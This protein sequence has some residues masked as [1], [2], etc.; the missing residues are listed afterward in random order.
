MLD[1]KTFDEGWPEF[2][3]LAEQ[4]PGLIQESVTRFDQ[5]LFGSGDIQRFY[6]FSFKDRQ[7]LEEALTTEIGE[8]AGK[9]LHIISGG[10]LTILA[11][12]FQSDT[13]DRISSFSSSTGD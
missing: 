8:K 12:D 9:L 10:N 5:V 2:L 6:A 11:G 7:A 1:L 4:M 3:E 13:L